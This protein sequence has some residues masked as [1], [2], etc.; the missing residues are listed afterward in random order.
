MIE[1][2]LFADPAGPTNAGVPASR[3]AKLKATTDPECFCS[4]DPAF[5][6]D[7]GA[8]CMAW[9]ALPED[10]PKQQKEKQKLRPIWVRW[11]ARRSQH[12][13]AYLAW[14]CMNSAEKTCSAYSE[15]KG[16]AD[17]LKRIA[18]DSL[19]TQANHCCF[20]RSM[21]NDIEFFLGINPSHAGDCA[22]ETDLR[23]AKQNRLLRNV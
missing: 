22:P 10:T 9:N 20:V 12:P 19:L 1:A 17:A 13:K 7:S 11:G 6:A 21:V 2:W 8:D 3:M 4:D 18:W 15:T 14:L 16:G 5:T 23:T